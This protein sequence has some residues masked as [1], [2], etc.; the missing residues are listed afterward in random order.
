MPIMIVFGLFS[1]PTIAYDNHSYGKDTVHFHEGYIQPWKTGAK[2]YVN[3]YL[4][5]TDFRDIGGDPFV[6][7][8]HGDGIRKIRLS[9]MLQNYSQTRNIREQD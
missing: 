6:T 2:I 3:S 1:V 8:D 5:Q 4:F 7:D 9:D